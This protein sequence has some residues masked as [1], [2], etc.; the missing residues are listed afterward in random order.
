MNIGIRDAVSF[1]P[2]LILDGEK[3]PPESFES[4]IGARTAMGQRLDG[5]I[6]MLAVDG[7]QGYSIGLTFPDVV[8]IMYDKFDCV[9]AV[10]MDGGNSTCM[11]Y[12][13]QL[14]NNSS[15]QA[16]GTRN[17]PDAWLIRKLPANYVKPDTVP[18]EIRIPF[19]ALGNVKEGQIPCDEEMTAR[20]TEFLYGFTNAYYG[21]FGTSNADYYY[22]TLLQYVADGSELKGRMDQAL[23]DRIWVNTYNNGLENLVVLGAYDNG[24]GTYDIDC[25]L[26]VTEYANYWTYLASDTHLS[27]TVYE[28]PGSYA[29]FLAVSTN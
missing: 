22:P 3:M 24:D 4:G 16:A 12:N 6:V 2:V 5:A 27:V 14:V 19:N 8:D 15:N 1:G 17:L 10:N 18:D 13:G 25:A 9:N 21:F 7:R 28:E 26:D 11:A 23:L 29:G 20:L